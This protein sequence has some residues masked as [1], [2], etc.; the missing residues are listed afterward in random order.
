MSYNILAKHYDALM[1]DFDYDALVE[2][3]ESVYN[4]YNKSVKSVVDLA[5]GSGVLTARLEK[6]GYDITAV[7]ISEEMLAEARERLSEN[8]LIL[9]QDMC[10]L[11][12]YT[13]YDAVLCSLDAINCLHSDDDV[14]RALARVNLFLEND[15]VFIFDINSAHK[16]K[17]IYPANTFTFESDLVYC[18]WESF[19]EDDLI[20]FELTFFEEG[21]DGRYTRYEDCITQRVYETEQMEMLIKRSGL[22][23]LE[24]RDESFLSPKDDSQRIYFICTKGETNEE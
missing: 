24:T 20:D 22:K 16:L 12:L 7:D 14:A 19:L 13:T 9:C 21:E 10:E 8:A 6:R 11:D 23:L 5:C 1:G 3:Y 15:G 4:K 17:N 2:F 18:I